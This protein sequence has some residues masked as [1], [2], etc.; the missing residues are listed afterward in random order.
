METEFESHVAQL[1]CWHEVWTD[2]DG[3]EGEAH[4]KYLKGNHCSGWIVS[5]FDTVHCCNRYPDDGTFEGI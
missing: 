5:S 2:R 4:E 3:L 1:R